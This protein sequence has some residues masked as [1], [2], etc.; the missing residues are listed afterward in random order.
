MFGFP[1]AQPFEPARWLQQGD[2]L[3]LGRETIH[4]LHCPGHTPGHVVFY[5]KPAAVAF[6]GDVLFAGSIGRTDFPKGNHEQLLTSIRERL[7]P[8]GDNTCV[9]PG[10]GPDT[11]VGDERATNPYVRDR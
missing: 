7:W 10:H 8:L 9:I 4:V 6:V 5:S 1:P 11:T 2:Q 3:S